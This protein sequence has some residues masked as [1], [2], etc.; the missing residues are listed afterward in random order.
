[1][2]KGQVKSAVRII[3]ILEYFDKVQRP[4]RISELVDELGYPQSSVSSLM[5]TLVSQ[6]YAR[7]DNDL[8][9]FSPT[10]R[11]AF[12]GHWAL[13]HYESVEIIQQ[14]MRNLTDL[15][16]ESTLLG[17]RN[18][19]NVQYVA[20][21]MT[22]SALAFSVR[23]G[24]LRPLH[25]ASLGIAL[26]TRNT[27]DEIG[28]II[29]RYDAENPAGPTSSVEE[30]LERVEK[31]RETGIA[32]TYDLGTTGAGVVAMLLPL[33]PGSRALAMG[34]GGPSS[35]IRDN[36]EFL[37]DALRQAVKDYSARMEAVRRREF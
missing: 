14:V 32:C 26:M 34:I 18:G 30:T 2:E 27:E 37:G 17:A 24:T 10:A 28:K 20:T 25:R 15:T 7:F 8:R 12:L 31:V 35:R 16:G 36:E 19:L 6:G 21:T 33:V 13:G 29:R 22:E 5:K 11:L 9:A 1:M 23:S 4:L 3:A